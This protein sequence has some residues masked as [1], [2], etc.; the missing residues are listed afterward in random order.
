MPDGMPDET[1]EQ[2]GSTPIEDASGL[3]PD[4]T[5]R[6][7]LDVAESLNILSAADWLESGRVSEVF[8]VRFY[9]ELHRKMFGEVWTWAGKLRSET[10]NQLRPPFSPPDRVPQDLGR[11][12][13]EFNREWA[14]LKDR[15]HIVPIIARYHHA[16][17]VV[18]PF[19]NGN[20]RWSRLAAD[21]VVQR[22]AGQSP[23]EWATEKATLIDDRRDR[24]EYL[25]ALRNA[26]RGNLG[27]LIGYLSELNPGR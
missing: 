24:S 22:L 5:T 27:P 4:L 23:L 1:T 8:T 14:E 20:G 13:M 19:N 17:V 26:D 9:Q 2:P 12:A 16:L 15:N 10:G 6:A 25:A 11:V 21:A 7:E 3:I 18:H